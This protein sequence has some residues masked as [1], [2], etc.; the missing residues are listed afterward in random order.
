MRGQKSPLL[1]FKIFVNNVTEKIKVV[2][3]KALIEKDS[4]FL[5]DVIVKGNTG[6]SKV[7]VILDG[8]DGLNIDDCASVSRE[9]SSFL[10]E[11]PD[12]ID[13]KFNLEVT[14][15]GLEH[16]LRLPRQ[17]KKNIG[18]NVKVLSTEYGEKEGKL[19][20]VEEGSIT[21][22]V[23]KDKKKGIVEALA[24]PISA[25]EKTNVLV[26]FK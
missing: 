17:Y 9:I 10:E 20:A 18:R 16:P 21:I 6:N 15:A 3:E 13:G 7:L 25:I 26:S 11:N 19:V 22:E 5:I 14:S 12:L 8:D 24:I 4:L 1:L 2:A 23:M